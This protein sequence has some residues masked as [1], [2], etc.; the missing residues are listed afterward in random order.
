MFFLFVIF[1]L[2]PL[3]DARIA[4]TQV[5]HFDFQKCRTGGEERESWNQ[6]QEQT[7]DSQADQESA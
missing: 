7:Q 2:P 5:R 4:S 1:L 3:R 6:W